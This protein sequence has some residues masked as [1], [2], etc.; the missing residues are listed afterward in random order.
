VRSPSICAA[1]HDPPNGWKTAHDSQGFAA[2]TGGWQHR[3]PFRAV[4]TD[5]K[6]RGRRSF[7]PAPPR[8]PLAAIV[9]NWQRRPDGSLYRPKRGD[10]GTVEYYWPD[11]RNALETRICRSVP[12]RLIAGGTRSG[13]PSASRV[14]FSAEA[15]NVIRHN[16]EW[17]A[18]NDGLEIGGLLEGRDRRGQIEVVRAFEATTDRST[19]AM[20]L[21]PFRRSGYLD[22]CVARGDW[23]CHPNGSL[24]PSDADMTA[25]RHEARLSG[26]PWVAVI[27]APARFKTPRLA[28]WLIAPG[29]RMTAVDIN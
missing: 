19:H 12:P 6:P 14:T 10:P 24:R 17:I 8:R 25:W 16:A 22:D 23:H 29:G 21:D 26:K 7:V 11:G 27:A 15:L 20:K 2:S 3:P 5:R 1:R 4:D 18:A 9:S 13:P 28:A